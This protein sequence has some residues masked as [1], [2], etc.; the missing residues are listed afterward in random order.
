MRAGH[1]LT[2]APSCSSVALMPLPANHTVTPAHGRGGTPAVKAPASGFGAGGG[3]TEHFA[4]D[5]TP[6]VFILLPGLM[7]Q[8]GSPTSL[9][10]L[11]LC[12]VI[13]GLTRA[14]GA[15]EGGRGP[16]RVLA[17][18]L[19]HPSTTREPA[20]SS[21]EGRRPSARSG[22]MGTAPRGK[23]VTPNGTEES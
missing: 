19:G 17:A 22:K 20:G 16:P 12:V 9:S 8:S 6:L 10:S 1:L 23:Q 11:L 15:Q 7:E 13:A 5:L 2:L 18:W 3:P 14:A 21:Q 4:R